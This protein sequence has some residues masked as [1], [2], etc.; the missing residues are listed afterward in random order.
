MLEESEA[1][2]IDIEEDVMGSD[3]DEVAT[4]VVDLDDDGISIDLENVDIS[5]GVEV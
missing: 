4:V 2:M 3:D 5:A 1:S